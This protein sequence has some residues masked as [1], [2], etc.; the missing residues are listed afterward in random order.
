M[1]LFIPNITL[2]EIDVMH[3]FVQAIDQGGAKIAFLE[4]AF[5][6]RLFHPRFILCLRAHFGYNFDQ[7]FFSMAL[8]LGKT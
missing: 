1:Q 6:P 7:T 4:S 8:A 3:I 5:L 2:K